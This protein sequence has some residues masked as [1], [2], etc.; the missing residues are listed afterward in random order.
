MTA[1]VTAG[2]PKEVLRRVKQVEIKARVLADDM[3]LGRYRS[4]FKGSGLEFEEVR[5]YEP[6]DEIRSID[7]NV[8]ARMGAPYIKKFREE[9]ELTIQLMVDTSASAWFGT[10]STSKRELAAEVAALLSI[11][12]LRNNDRVGL[13]QFSDRVDQFVPPRKGRDQSL[14]IIRDLLMTEPARRKTDVATALRFLG[15]IQKRRAVIFV[16]SDFY[17]QGFER[18]MR[19]LSKR[20]DVIAVTL[21]D[22]REQTLPSVGVIGLED[23]ETGQVRYIDTGKRQ[24]RE[25]YARAA[26]QRREER[27]R[28]FSRMGVERVDLWT[29][30]PY[31]PA[32]MALF[33][34]K[35]RH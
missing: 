30:R 4:V 20:H 33:S 31:V 3:L 19:M 25:A 21:N 11:A 13:I 32:L 22:P 18:P 35:G 29:N 10:T 12:A 2:V 17:D 5:E 16:V 6:G 28:A 15:N 23:A 26:V 27:M 1:T 34:R 14:R 8:T 7:W 24:V 9:R